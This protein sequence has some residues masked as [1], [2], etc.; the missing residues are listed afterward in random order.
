MLYHFYV[1]SKLLI[2]HFMFIL[3]KFCVFKVYAA[4]K[5]MFVLS[6]E[7]K[8]AVESSFSGRHNC[9]IGKKRIHLFQ[10]AGRYLN[11][12]RLK[13]MKGTCHRSVLT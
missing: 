3:P 11:I 2:A 6:K 8:G 12:N 4:A 10:L 7:R 5:I 1:S 13:H 9:Q